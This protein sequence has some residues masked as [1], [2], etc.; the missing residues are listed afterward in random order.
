[1]ATMAPMASMASIATMEAMASM[2][3]MAPMA[4][5]V[6]LDTKLKGL[7]SLM[8]WDMT[9]LGK[10]LCLLAIFAPKMN[11]GSERSRSSRRVGKIDGGNPEGLP[12]FEGWWAVVASMAS[13]ATM[14]QGGTDVEVPLVLGGDEWRRMVASMGGW[15]VDTEGADVEVTLCPQW[16]GR[17]AQ[18]YFDFSSGQRAALQFFSCNLLVSPYLLS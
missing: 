5:M 8:C 16:C 3:S 10:W 4:S 7:V 6:P 1:M 18:T 9:T 11:C 12:I 13:M 2:D 17:H 14:T 15:C